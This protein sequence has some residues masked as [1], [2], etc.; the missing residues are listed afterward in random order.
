MP[1]GHGGVDHP[2][3]VLTNIPV[4]WLALAVPLAWRR[5]SEAARSS[6]RWFLVALI[7]LAGTSA[8]T[9][10]L[11]YA[12]CLRYQGDFVPELVLLAAIG[13]LAVDASL[14]GRLAWRRAARWCW[15]LLLTFSVLFNLFASF[16]RL[17]ETH[18][19]LGNLQLDAGQTE[20]AIAHFQRA[21]EFSPNNASTHN[22]LGIA[23]FRIGRV[24]KAIIQFRKAVALEPTAPEGHNNLGNALVRKG[25]TDEAIIEIRKAVE[26]QPDD[27]TAQNILAKLLLH[28]G[29]PD[30]AMD[31]LRRAVQLEPEAGRCS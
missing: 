17:A 5:R 30:E 20:Q 31:H 15:G 9:V 14:T 27:A 21:L 1:T 12:V 19:G 16:D 22:D 28:Q 11:Y 7:W 2:F 23:L 24:D 13:I 10:G 3:G 4:V 25:S 29:Q 26:I 6:L 8:L 18:A